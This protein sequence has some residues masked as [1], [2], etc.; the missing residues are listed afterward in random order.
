MPAI[1]TVVYG[2]I[3]Y[4]DVVAINLGSEEIMYYILRKKSITCMFCIPKI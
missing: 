4:N 2:H 1:Y 3:T